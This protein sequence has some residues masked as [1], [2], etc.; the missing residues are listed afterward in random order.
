MMVIK[1]AT[2]VFKDSI[3]YI[4]RQVDSSN[5]LFIRCFVAKY[6]RVYGCTNKL[7]F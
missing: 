1:L 6:I 3:S 7:I 5:V 4:I 2:L